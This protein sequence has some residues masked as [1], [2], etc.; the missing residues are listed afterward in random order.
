LPCPNSTNCTTFNNHHIIQH[1]ISLNTE[2]H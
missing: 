1:Y 2:C